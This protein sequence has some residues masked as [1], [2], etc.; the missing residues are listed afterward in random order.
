MYGRGYGGLVQAGGHELEQRHL[1][2]GVLHCDAVG[3]EVGVALAAFHLL[4]R[5][6]DEVIDEDLLSQRQRTPESVPTES[7]SF[8]QSCV[9]GFDEFRRGG[10]SRVH[11]DNYNTS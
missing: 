3:V 5:W 8:V 7:D 10:G 1:R 2:G 11:V 4:C 6:V 9:D